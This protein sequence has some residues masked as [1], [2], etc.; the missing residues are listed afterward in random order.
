M[1]THKNSYSSEAA[2]CCANPLTD[3]RKAR[4]REPEY[5]SD[6]IRTLKKRFR[7]CTVLDVFTIKSIPR[8]WLLQNLLCGSTEL[9]IP[10]LN[11]SIQSL[12]PYTLTTTKSSIISTTEVRML[13][14]NLL[15]L[16]SKRSELLKEVLEIS[17]SSYLGFRKFM[18]KI[19]CS[20]YFSI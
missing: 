6:S 14:L 12:Q 16:K 4:K 19:Y 17:I 2:T 7:L 8:T 13:L 20:T 5:F 3:G 11:L 1:E 10:G 9:P 15:M 18:P